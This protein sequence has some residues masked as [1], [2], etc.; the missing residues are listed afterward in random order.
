VDVPTREPEPVDGSE[1][2]ILIGWLRFHRDALATKTMGLTAE[3]L[4]AAAAPPSALTILG[5]VRHMTEMERVY[6]AWA[7]GGGGELVFVYGDYVDGG[8]EWD[9]DVDS[10]MVEASMVNWR[11]ECGA[12]DQ[13]LANAGS[14]D[15]IGSGNRR[16]VRWN[17]QKL[18]GE[19]A[20]HNGHADIVRERIDGSTGE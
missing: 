13:A 9:F 6:G 8:P 16:S 7:I 5:L 18:V 10:S 14:L 19:Y 4:T 15:T 12:T 17:L 3:Q 11:R 1:T 20:R 2:D